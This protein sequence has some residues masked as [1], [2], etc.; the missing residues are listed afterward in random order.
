MSCFELED[1]L[2]RRY[3]E[4]LDSGIALSQLGFAPERLMKLFNRWAAEQAA[5]PAM[6]RHREG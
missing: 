5:G 1:G 4:K 6:E 2:I 3:K